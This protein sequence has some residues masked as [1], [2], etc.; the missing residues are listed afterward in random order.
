MNDRI[1]VRITVLSAMLLPVTT[2]AADP[3][4]GQELH[5]ENCI[6]CHQSMMAGEDGDMYLR[7]DHIVGSYPSLVTQVR[8][9]E[10]N[11]SLQWFDEDVEDVA[12]YLNER[13][14]HF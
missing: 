12:S 11:L 1:V 3:E 5:Q 4:S 9:C 13:Y 10:V 6:S 8:R 14:Y 2:S 7:D